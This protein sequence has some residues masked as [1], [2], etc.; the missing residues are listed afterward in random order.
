MRTSSRSAAASTLVR[1]AAI[2]IVAPRWRL[3][4]SAR[5]SAASPSAS[6]AAL[7]SSSRRIG[8]SSNIARA[9]AIRCR[10]PADSARPP[11]PIGQS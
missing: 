9:S 3:V 2:T 6:S 1:C 10:C 11:R 4:S 5:I 7:G 8:G